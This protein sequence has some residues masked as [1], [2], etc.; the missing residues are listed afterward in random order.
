MTLDLYG[1]LSNTEDTNV[2][3]ALYDY[4]P[5]KTGSEPINGSS[6]IYG[7]R[8]VK[9]LDHYPWI[10]IGADLYTFQ[11]NSATAKISPLAVSG[12]IMFR[13]PDDTWKP[14]MGLGLSSSVCDIDISRESNLGIEISETSENSYGW[15]FSTG[16]VWSINSHILLFTE[17]RYTHINVDFGDEKFNESNTKIDVTLNSN[18]Y[19]IGVSFPL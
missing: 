8:V 9:W 7:I 3:I 17:Y 10:G 1:G 4:A 2:D 6:N 15:D 16:L 11:A 14:Y 18:H 13:Y 5:A 19:L 12:T